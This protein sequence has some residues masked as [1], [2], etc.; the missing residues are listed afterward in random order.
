MVVLARPGTP[1]GGVELGGVPGPVGPT[2]RVT[3]V[4]RL[5]LCDSLIPGVRQFVCVKDAKNKGITS[6]SLELAAG[7]G[8][9]LFQR[10]WCCKGRR[11]P[12]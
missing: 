7:V 4:F 6:K 2:G 9:L 8:H 5:I 12:V 11:Y 3:V 1:G 10:L